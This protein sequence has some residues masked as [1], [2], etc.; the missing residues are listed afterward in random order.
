MYVVCVVSVCPLRLCVG[1]CSKIMTV[2][3]LRLLEK[4]AV[5][6]AF[7][8]C[9]LASACTQ[10]RLWLGRLWQGRDTACMPHE[11]EQ[12]GCAGLRWHTLGIA[13]LPH[14]SSTFIALVERCATYSSATPRCG[15]AHIWRRGPCMLAA[16]THFPGSQ[17]TQ[18]PHPNTPART[19]PTQHPALPRHHWA[20]LQ[21]WQ[22]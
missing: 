7:S 16:S 8:G 9:L 20:S 4:L 17:P 15:C 21:A 11:P 5:A 12:L 22:P 19:G 3:R 13:W 10:P 6:V 1:R 14:A 18:A 2:V